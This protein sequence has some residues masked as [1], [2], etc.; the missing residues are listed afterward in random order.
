MGHDFLVI[1]VERKMAMESKPSEATL[2]QMHRE[3]HPAT[4]ILGNTTGRR[5]CMQTE[6]V[7]TWID[8]GTKWIQKTLVPHVC[9]QRHGK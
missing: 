9:R 1:S 7:S 5:L 4:H 3:A 2:R 6:A 8:P